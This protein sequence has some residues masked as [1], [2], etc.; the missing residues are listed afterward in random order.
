[1][2]HNGVNWKLR[3]ARRIG[4]FAPKNATCSLPMIL[5]P[6]LYYVGLYLRGQGYRSEEY[7][8]GT[9]A[10][11]ASS[12]LVSIGIPFYVDQPC[13]VSHV[14]I[15]YDG[16]P[17]STPDNVWLTFQQSWPGLGIFGPSK[18]CTEHLDVHKQ[19]TDGFACHFA[20][21]EA[22]GLVLRVNDVHEGRKQV[23]P[24]VIGAL[25]QLLVML[26]LVVLWTQTFPQCF[27]P[28]CFCQ[29]APESSDNMTQPLM[30]QE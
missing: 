13:Y 27:K 18:S 9:C 1:M 10:I 26:G 24:V 25:G 5:V 23:V 30:S 15:S 17:V 6:I 3:V 20:L 14:S 8:D 22:S 4:W 12:A 7:F 2:A 16:K 19:K 21:K 28:Q 11:A 29:D